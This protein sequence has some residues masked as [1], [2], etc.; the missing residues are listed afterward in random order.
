MS[1]I[2]H[3]SRANL[4][5]AFAAEHPGLSPVQIVKQLGTRVSGLKPPEVRKALG[6]GDKRRIKSIAP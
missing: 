5:R 2:V 4:V 1:V 6:T 3:P